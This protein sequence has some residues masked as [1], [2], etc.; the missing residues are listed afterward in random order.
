[1]NHILC[2]KANNLIWMPKSKYVERS[3][4][5]RNRNEGSNILTIKPLLHYLFGMVGSTIKNRPANITQLD[6]QDMQR[7]HDANVSMETNN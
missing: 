2:L 4:N 6:H 7:E 1:M 5:H 3:S